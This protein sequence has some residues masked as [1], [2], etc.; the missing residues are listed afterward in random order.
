MDPKLSVQQVN[1]SELPDDVA[2]T[3]LAPLIN[4]LRQKKRI[5]IIAGAGLSAS[6]GSKKL[7]SSV[8]PRML[9][10]LVPTFD[11]L[12][13]NRRKLFD[14]QMYRDA[15]STKLVNEMMCDMYQSVQAARPTKAHLMIAD[16]AKKGLIQRLYTQNIDGIDTQLEPLKTSIP[17]PQKK[18][19]PIAIQ[20]HGDLRTVSCKRDHLSRFDPALFASKEEPCCTICKQQDLL[21]KRRDRIRS[22]PVLRPRICKYNQSDYPDDDAI[23]KVKAADFR[24]RPDAV[25]VI[26]TALKVGAAKTFARD[27][28]RTARE[29][30]GFTA[31]INIKIP[32]R[33][34]DCLDLIVKGDCDTVAEHVSGWWLRDCPNPLSDAH[35][36]ELQEKCKVFISRSPKAALKRAFSEVDTASLCKILQQKEIKARVLSV[37]EDG[38][39]VFFSAEVSQSSG[40]RISKTTSHNSEMVSR[41]R[42]GVYLEPVKSPPQSPHILPKLPHCWEAEMSKRLGEVVISKA[43][44]RIGGTSLV[45]RITDLGYRDAIADSLW[46]LKPGEE[47]NDEI[48]NAY[49][50]L[51]RSSLSAVQSIEETTILTLQPN[52]PWKRSQKL[53][54][55]GVYSIFIPVHASHHW[56]FAV[57]RSKK[58]G[59]L[60]HWEYY[61]SLGGQPP[62]KLLT[63]I[64]GRFP[65]NT[66]VAAWPNPRQKNGVDCGLFVLLGIRLMSAGEKHLSQADSDGIISNFRQRVL[67][68]L[69]A[70]SINPSNSQ[71][72][73]FKKREAQTNSTR[74]EVNS[75]EKA[76]HNSTSTAAGDSSQQIDGLARE[77]SPGL[78]IVSTPVTSSKEGSETDFSDA[79]AESEEEFVQVIPT[80][81]K[82]PRTKKSPEQIASNFAQLESMYEM[83]ADVTQGQRTQSKIENLQRADLWVMISKEKRGLR[84]RYIHYEFSRQFWAEMEEHNRSPYQ[85]GR[86]PNA[87]ISIIMSKFG[88]NDK[89]NWKYVLQRARRGSIWTELADIFKNDLKYPSIVLCAVPDATHTLETMTLTN[90]KV[91]VEIIR[92]RIK[93]PGEEILNRLKHASLLYGA[94]MRNDPLPAKDLPIDN[95]ATN[96][97]AH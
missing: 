88:I 59:D 54:E 50:E 28:C 15:E 68:E 41:R 43:G 11:D 67:A 35:I 60:V 46:R 26:G 8:S 12:P 94:A 39:A 51:L 85:H 52:R 77:S 25:I 78:F 29:G 2:Q 70:F 93:E 16:L 73:E 31:W 22:A 87:V 20:L 96:N 3:Q 32:P 90:R 57:L 49:L 1:L 27:M 36:Q 23:H 81:Q 14:E 37:R 64:N 63:W 79:L 56:T 89:T 24:A 30:G 75:L 91:L 45:T 58:K 34:F 7:L 53:I 4:A 21:D 33:D 47:L 72:D 80:L 86:V 74:L 55:T 95:L 6:A 62:Q 61:D 42:K 44:T 9:N 71:F 65:D 84:Q 13:A 92:S 40:K 66:E 17:L 83:M 48:L 69:L 82:V 19:W 38:H 76:G 5:I 10:Q 18:P 97:T